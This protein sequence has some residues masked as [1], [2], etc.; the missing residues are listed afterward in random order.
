[1][2]VPALP[3][4]GHG[5]APP[6]PTSKVRQLMTSSISAGR[7][8]GSVVSLV[9]FV[10]L[11][12][13]CSR[14]EQG[15][16][17]LADT[18]A[19]TVVQ[20]VVVPARIEP[21][22]HVAVAAPVGGQVAELFVRDGHH[23]A[24]GVPVLRLESEGVDLAVAQAHAGVEASSALA[25]VAPAPDLSPLIAVIRGQVE[26]I[27]PPLLATAQATA[28]AIPDPKARTDALARVAEAQASYQR[29]AQDLA[30][31]EEQARGATRRATTAQRR[32]AQAQRK[33]AEAA[34]AAARIRQ[35]DLVVRAPTSGIVEFA[36]PA[37][38]G[39]PSTTGLPGE[40]GDLIGDARLS[41]AGEPVTVGARAVPGQTL[42][43]IYDLSG[44]HV[45][46]EVYE[47]DAVLI[48][49]GQP[50]EIMV[51]AH[52]DRAFAGRVERVGI[53]PVPTPADSV[54]YPVVVV[55][56]A[57]PLDVPLRVGMTA[58]VE[59]V[60]KRVESGTIVPTR[61]LL[62]RDGRDVVIVTREGR[63][64]EVAVTP[65][66]FGEDEAAVEGDVTPDDHIVVAGFDQL[67][68]GDP[69]PDSQEAWGAHDDPPR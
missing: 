47:V 25:A 67:E 41:D 42:F 26:E 52:P 28:A 27:V 34:L 7:G 45:R 62:R 69:L 68:D 53:A 30:Y 31:A 51:D 19:G 20:T 57:L 4:E 59:I 12:A 50:A 54:V 8:V 22:G 55:F 44:F 40:L 48:A 60:V 33:Q 46:G 65:L 35:A 1:M 58:S 64:R 14:G 13:G 5:P 2:R 11:L 32:A 56:D 63:A 18:G 21:A 9:G 29:T 38:K 49:E 3:R 43:K 15:G 24:A 37:G 16:I 17:E 66:A 10:L 23:V 61:A 36:H 6:R 39:S